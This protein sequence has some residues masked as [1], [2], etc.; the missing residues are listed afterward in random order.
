MVMLLEQAKGDPSG[1]AVN[2]AALDRLAKILASKETNKLFAKMKLNNVNLGSASKSFNKQF[3]ESFPNYYIWP[4]KYAHHDRETLAAATLSDE[5][6]EES[7]SETRLT[8]MLDLICFDIYHKRFAKAHDLLVADKIKQ[9]VESAAASVDMS[10]SNSISSKESRKSISLYYDLLG[11]FYQLSCRLGDAAAAYITALEFNSD[12]LDA[13]LKL[14]VLYIEFGEMSKAETAYDEWLQQLTQ[15]ATTAQSASLEATAAADTT[16]ESP[17]AAAAV[18]RD[19][20]AVLTE[21]WILTHRAGLWTM[22]G[23]EGAY[24]PEAINL[25]ITDITRVRSLTGE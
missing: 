23:S 2:A 14:I 16:V 22:R 19:S 3:F 7:N 6:S 5:N 18:V 8:H 11:S 24:M 13:R 20:T 17:P 9:L 12:N 10:D 15:S 1:G 21:A 4:M 25:A